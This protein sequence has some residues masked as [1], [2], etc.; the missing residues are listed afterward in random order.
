MIDLADAP[1]VDPA[2][3]KAA[4]EGVARKWRLFAG[5]MEWSAKVTFPPLR[6]HWTAGHRL[7]GLAGRLAHAG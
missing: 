1:T 7:I 5:R 3:F 4:A 2:K 6:A